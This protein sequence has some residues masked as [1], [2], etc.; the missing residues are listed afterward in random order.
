MNPTKAD[1][2]H[3]GQWLIRLRR[4]TAAGFEDVTK[5]VLADYTGWLAQDFPL[6][7]FTD[8][9]V[10]FIAEQSQYFP[11]WAILS[12]ALMDWRGKHPDV[13]RIEGPMSESVR[14]HISMLNNDEDWQR[15]QMELRVD[16]LASWRDPHRVAATVAKIRGIESD[17]LSTALGCLL[18][19]AVK[20]HAPENLGFVAPQWQ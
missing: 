8:A 15:E 11:K 12:A 10:K 13:P 14:R 17:A 5:E 3:I 20:R 4:V 2:Q 6:S 1:M 18:A 9:S 19:I 7:V 16:C